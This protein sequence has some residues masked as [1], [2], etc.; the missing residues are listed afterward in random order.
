MFAYYLQLGLRSLRKNPLLT[1]L[2]V[3]AIGCGVAASM[4]TYSVFRATSNN[5][6]PDKSSQLYVPQIDNWGPDAS[7]DNKGEPPNAMT[8]TD[9]INLMRDKRAK[10]QTAL[11]PA[12]ISIV[13][14]DPSMLP[15]RETSYAW[16]ADAFAMFDIPFLYGH[17]WTADEDES[18]AAVAVIGK[19]LNDKLFNGA[20]S[21]GKNVSINGRDYRIVGV[22]DKWNPEPVFYDVINTN[23][24]DDPIEVFI[25]FTRAVELQTNT[26]GNNNCSHDPGKG[27]DSWIRSECVWLGFWAELPTTSEA[28]AYRAYLNGYAAEQQRAGRFRWAPNTRLRNVTE[29]L[30]YQKVVPQEAKVSLMVSLGFLLICLVNTVGLLLAKF[31]RRSS[32][33]GVRRALGAPRKEIYLQFLIEAAAVGLAGGVVGLLLTGLGVMGVS[34]VFEPDVARLAK[35]D[36]SLVLLTMLVAVLTTVLAAFYPTWRAAQVQPAWQLKSN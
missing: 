23:G 17:A 19:A 31:M 3:L 6:I 8:Y 30:D 22:A 29:W 25:P 4:T 34:L 36:V 32:E 27:W 7:K 10:R 15:F 35:L 11:Y 16:Y 13:P 24:F 33:I 12:A 2:M 9:A 18:H 5:P 26:N 14:T 21:V 28:D 1:L 20:N